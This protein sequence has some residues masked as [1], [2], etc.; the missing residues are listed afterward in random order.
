MILS[1]EYMISSPSLHLVSHL[2]AP[3]TIGGAGH[4]AIMIPLQLVMWI[5]VAIKTPDLH[6]AWFQETTARMNSPRHFWWA[7]H[8]NFCLVL[9]FAKNILNVRTTSTKSIE[10][11]VTPC[12]VR[13]RMD[14]QQKIVFG[15]RFTIVNLLHKL[16]YV[17]SPVFD[18]FNLCASQTARVTQRLYISGDLIMLL[19]HSNVQSNFHFPRASAL[20]PVSCLTRTCN[21]FNA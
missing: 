11:I 10:L 17:S 1:K 15:L 5:N 6:F 2:P 8:S 4:N 9:E 13:L 7:D 18:H 19:I 14:L 20:F 12:I 16:S 3:V 21:M